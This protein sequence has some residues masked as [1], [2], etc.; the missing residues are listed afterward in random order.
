MLQAGCGNSLGAS[1]PEEAVREPLV[2]PKHGTGV[3]GF[4]VLGVRSSQ[5]QAIVIYGTG[6]S[7]KSQT[8]SYMF[9]YAFVTYDGSGWNDWSGHTTET[10]ISF[11]PK[12]KVC[13]AVAVGDNGQEKY[14][15]VYG[16]VPSSVAAVSIDFSNGAKVSDVSTGGVFGAISPNATMPVTLRT[17]GGAGQVLYQVAIPAMQPPVH[18]SADSTAFT[19]LP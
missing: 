7:N 19:C 6:V 16:R 15:L 11:L 2:H 9:G 14:A 8:T 18:N 4:Q 5:G 12:W 1:T 10:S 17:L 3:Q 13:Y